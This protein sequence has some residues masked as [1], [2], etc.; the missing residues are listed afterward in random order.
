[1]LKPCYDTQFTEMEDVVRSIEAYKTV[2]AS[3]ARYYNEKTKRATFKILTE[4]ETIEDGGGTLNRLDEELGWWL[5]NG[6]EVTSI[7]PRVDNRIDIKISS[8]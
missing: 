2:F 6:Y 8:I 5:E 7:I 1:M 4:S 3:N